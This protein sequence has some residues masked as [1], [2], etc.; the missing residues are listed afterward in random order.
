MAPIILNDQNF[1][2]EVIK[3]DLPVLVDFWATW[4]GPCI[5]TA[6]VIEELAGQYEGK[7]KVGK[8]NVDE[9]PQTAEKFRIMSIPT[10]ILF[11][12]GLETK[13]QVGFGGK[14]RYVKL[15]E[16]ALK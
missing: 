9:N 16:E 13:R 14:E 10:V 3:N 2:N 8:L 4:C 6:P 15:L 12:N 11:Q 1:E 7:V 5:M